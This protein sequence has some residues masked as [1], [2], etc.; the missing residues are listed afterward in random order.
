M[1]EYVLFEEALRDR[2]LKFIAD[3]G[4][5]GNVRPDPMGG[6]IVALPDDLAE[7]IEAAVEDG[8]ATLM[9][10]QRNL[11]D[12]AGDDGARNVMSVSVTLAD[13]QQRIVRLPFRHARRLYDHFSF[14][15]IHDL[16]SAIAES[17]ANP[18]EGPTCRRI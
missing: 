11:L 4:L 18:V 16:V 14:E 1:S 9:E 3:R 10:E 2:F 6:F 7:E 13:G 5:A 17:V 8:Y 12:S 15:E